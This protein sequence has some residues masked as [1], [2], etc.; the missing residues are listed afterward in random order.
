LLDA[1]SN[2]IGFDEAVHDGRGGADFEGAS[3]A[4][5]GAG[6]DVHFGLDHLLFKFMLAVVVVNSATY[7]EGVMI[8]FSSGFPF[9]L[10][11]FCS[12]LVT[13]KKISFSCLPNV[14]LD[15]RL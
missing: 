1:T 9:Y 7:L 2:T 6:G 13:T 5:N 3:V 10:E 12:L 15:S 11:I 8:I 14:L 4:G